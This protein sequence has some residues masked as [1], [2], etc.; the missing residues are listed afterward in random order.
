[1][2]RQSPRPANN[3]APS[4]DDP[5]REMADGAP[6][7][8]VAEL[9]A[10]GMAHHQAGRL[11]EAEAHYRR[12]LGIV[13]DHADVLHLLG[14]IA[15]QT[16]RHEA[17]IELIGR[18]IERNDSDPSYHCSR[19]LVLQGLD[20]LDEALA[21]YDRALLLNPDYAAALINRGVALQALERFA[22]ALESHDRALA[23][24]P[25][26]A[27]AWLNRGNTLQQLGRFA[28]ALESYDRALAIR[29]DLVEA[30]YNRAETLHSLVRLGEERLL[31]LE[32][33]DEA[34]AQSDRALAQERLKGALASYDRVLAL[35]SD[36]AGISMSRGITLQKLGR[37]TEALESYDRALALGPDDAEIWIG[38]GVTLQGL[39]RLAEALESYDRALALKPISAAAVVDRGYILQQLG[40]F[41]E[42]L[43]SYD[44]AL[45]TRPDF[46]EAWLNRGNALQQLGRFVEALES[47]D[48]ALAVR[49]DFLGALL[50]RGSALE[51]L[52]RYAEALENYDRALAVRPDYAEAL[53][54]R[55]NA[56][57]QL[58]RF[59]EALDS[60][61]RALAANRYYSEAMFN[62]GNL[63]Q[64]LGNVAEALEGYDQTLDDAARS[65]N[66]GFALPSQEQP[67]GAIV[68]NQAEAL[69]PAYAIGQ[70]F[71]TK[72]R[73]WDWDNYDEGE[74]KA[75]H[76]LRTSA[77]RLAPFA[78]L[79]LSSTPEEQLE[80]ARHVTAAV[81]V[82][83]PSMLPRAKPR[84][85]E[86]IRL[87]YFSHDFRENAVAILISGLIEEH[88]RQRFEIVGYSY[89]PDDHSAHR[90]RL[91]G[92]FDR[93]VDI[94]DM[95]DGEAA[96]LIHADAVDILID[97]NG[98]TGDFEGRDP[99]LPASADPG[100]LSW[101]YR[102]N[103]GRLYRLH[104]R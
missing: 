38:R 51:E 39:G 7:P 20:R 69:E 62:R 100:Q 31:S 9:L 87:G 101:F 104:H 50:N 93:F 63:V 24:V 60:Y 46:A 13:P 64:K 32:H 40:R 85:T 36:Y 18:A 76:A 3:S 6:R 75:R 53:N 82:R 10:A 11:A 72:Q 21:G 54:N 35:R 88:D 37:L 68:S 41:G 33:L 73:L 98:Y 16:G 70:W 19:G 61:N 92:A 99:R 97:L 14:G 22:E 90:A 30:H 91:E 29:S 15:Y 12:V 94:R 47:Y 78:L 58:G 67:N 66:R 102:H 84:P 103:G 17:A 1:M 28:E 48:R 81:A 23:M 65:H 42:A 43:E 89:G 52:G 8:E 74:A 96:E 95:R 27:A 80:C 57:Q 79:A 49:P 25:D 34:V 86:K 45:A 44:Q 2:N 83:A 77:S 59:G 71:N 56:L 55:G 26:F 5:P 4:V